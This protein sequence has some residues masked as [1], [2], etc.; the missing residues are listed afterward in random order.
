MFARALAEGEVCEYAPDAVVFHHHRE[1]M[2]QL[3]WQTWGYGLSEGAMC[4]KYA[5][6][7]RGRRLHAAIRYLRLLRDHHRRLVAVKQGTD[8]YPLDLVVLEWVGIALGPIAY[9]LSVAQQGRARA[10]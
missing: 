5:L 8:R 2:S 9:L 4:A 3:R 7:R 6:A 10:R 1:N